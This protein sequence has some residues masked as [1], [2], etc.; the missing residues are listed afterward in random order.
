MFSELKT[1]NN[2]EISFFKSTRILKNKHRKEYEFIA[3]SPC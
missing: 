1:F 2:N 3:K